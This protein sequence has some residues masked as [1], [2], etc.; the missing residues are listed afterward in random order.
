MYKNFV[1][2]LGGVVVDYS[3]K[4]YLVDMF[5]HEKTEK[6]IYDAV[7]GSK[8]WERM[9]KGEL[10]FAE[11]A[12]IFMQRGRDK[13]IEMEMQAV[14]DSWLEMLTTRKA[15]VNLMRLF[16]KNGFNLYY[17][18]NISR[19]ALHEVSKRSFW[20]MFDGGIASCDVGINK[21][22]PAIYQMLIDKYSLVPQETI[23]TDDRREN[24][25]SSFHVGITGIQF[26]NVKS[27]CKMLITYGVDL[28]Q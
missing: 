3:P 16:K 10:T 28:S 7:F 21:P 2:D 5:F 15:T 17:L 22:D 25:L 8:E 14:V 1:F 19:E 23:F 18:S 11:A 20:P 27:L 13:D 24:A 26:K 4:E 9:D 12:E 6:K